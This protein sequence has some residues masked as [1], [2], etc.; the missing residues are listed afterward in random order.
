MRQVA[1]AAFEL[2]GSLA[3][4]ELIAQDGAFHAEAGQGCA[5][6][7][8][9]FVRDVLARDQLALPILDVGRGPESVVFEFEHEVIMGERSR[10]LRGRNRGDA[11]KHI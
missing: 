6:P 9:G 1:V 7:R 11:G 2:F 4:P 5:E 10:Y 8:K 3:A